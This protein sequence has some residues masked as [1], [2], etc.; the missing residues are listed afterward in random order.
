MVKLDWMTGIAVV[1]NM[2]LMSLFSLLGVV[3]S[4]DRCAILHP[5]LFFLS[6]HSYSPV[7]FLS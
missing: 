3:E 7:L 4:K 6:S 1:V 5:F 2:F